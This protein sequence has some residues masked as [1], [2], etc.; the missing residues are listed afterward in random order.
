M[1]LLLDILKNIPW[2]LFWFVV[3]FVVAIFTLPGGGNRRAP[4][5]FVEKQHL[6][7]RLNAEALHISTPAEKEAFI[8]KL[9]EC[10]PRLWKEEKEGILRHIGLR[11]PSHN[12]RPVAMKPP[13]E[14]AVR[15]ELADD[16]DSR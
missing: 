3:L 13:I 14:I 15:H 8:R 9:D 12:N 1:D 4:K 16:V 6:I 10:R 11:P 7:R 2:M 5:W